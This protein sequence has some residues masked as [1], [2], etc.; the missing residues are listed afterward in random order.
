MTAMSSLN[1]SMCE[2]VPCD[3]CG[4]LDHEIIYSKIDHVTNWE[5]HVVRCSCGMVFVNPMPFQDH[6]HLLYP[7]HYLDEKPLLEN[8]YSRMLQ[9]LPSATNGNKLLDIGCG[10]GDF[11]W[12]ANQHGWDAEGVDFTRWKNFRK[13]L[14]ITFGDFL[15]MNQGP[16]C[17]N[18]I[19]AWAVM[20]HVR[21]PSLYFK[22]VSELIE[23][24]GKFV[25]TVPNVTSPGMLYS[26]DEDTP[27]HLWLFTPDAIKK[28][29]S[30]C[31]MRVERSIHDGSVY[32]A[33]PFGLLRLGFNLLLGNSHLRCKE[34]QNKSVALLKNKPMDL[35]FKTWLR[36]VLRR[37]SLVDIGIDTL[38]LSLG[39]LVGS[40]SKFIKNYGVM[41]IVAVK[42]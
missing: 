3:L 16:S 34:F 17:F 29:L 19:T 2:Y 37:L 42:D 39:I 6:L 8:L 28:Y 15:L 13:G 5:F 22:R 30:Q 10:R 31:G 9:I 36:D 40:V 33:Y 12:Y 35:Y 25:F 18:V 21:N 38:D 20:E 26:C 14:R 24:K 23:S 32:R 11:V 27:R 41:T 7:S 1:D 4:S